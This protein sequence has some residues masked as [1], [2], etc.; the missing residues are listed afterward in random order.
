MTDEN[1]IWVEGPQFLINDFFKQEKYLLTGTHEPVPIFCIAILRPNRKGKNLRYVIIRVF[2][3]LLLLL[4][5]FIGFTNEPPNKFAIKF[6]HFRVITWIFNQTLIVDGDVEHILEWW[7]LNDRDIQ[8]RF[9]AGQID[10]CYFGNLFFILGFFLRLWLGLLGV[11]VDVGA[12][13]E[14]VEEVSEVV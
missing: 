5:F 1:R 14:R 10:D 3:C 11:E 6:T 4:R 2:A 7:L 8:R 9:F 12:K 13:D